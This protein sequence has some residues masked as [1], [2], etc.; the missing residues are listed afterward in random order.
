MRRFHSYG[1]V[2]QDIH[3]CVPRVKLVE[4]CLNHAMS[5]FGK[6]Q[7]TGDFSLYILVLGCHHPSPSHSL[8][9]IHIG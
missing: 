6:S 8:V 4:D 9:D 1:P 3:F 2:D 5:L 7:I